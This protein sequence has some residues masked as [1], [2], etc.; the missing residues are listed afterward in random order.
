MKQ[1]L[2]IIYILHKRLLFIILNHTRYWIFIYTKKQLNLS[3]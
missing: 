1:L 2:F 3:L